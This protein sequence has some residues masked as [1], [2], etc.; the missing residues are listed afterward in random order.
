MKYR[1]LWGVFLRV[2]APLASSELPKRQISVL[3]LVVMW[4]SRKSTGS[5]VRQT[6]HWLLVAFLTSCV[7]LG[8]LGLLNLSFLICKSGKKLDSPLP[9]VKL[10]GA[11]A[12]TMPY[13]TWHVG[14][15]LLHGSSPAPSSFEVLD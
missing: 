7:T 12:G 8:A 6:W 9:G 10:L 11:L 13:D 1:F 15:R 3:A 4:C 5:G 2:D 14:S